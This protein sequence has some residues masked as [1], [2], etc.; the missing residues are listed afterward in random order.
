MGLLIEI[1]KELSNPLMSTLSIVG[2]VAALE[3]FKAV[4]AE[5]NFASD[6]EGRGHK[7]GYYSAFL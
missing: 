4:L 6:Y 5:A 3:F 1:S 7:S 2:N